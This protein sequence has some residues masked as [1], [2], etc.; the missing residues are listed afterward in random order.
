L[1]AI[2]YAVIAA[3]GIYARRPAEGPVMA[4]VTA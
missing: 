2:C 4:P 1:P 3:F